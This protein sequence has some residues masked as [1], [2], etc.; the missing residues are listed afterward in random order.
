MNRKIV[1]LGAGISGL[2]LGWFL[3]QHLG[4]TAVISLL[5]Q[6]N[7][8]G[9]WIRTVEKG[10]FLFDCGPRSCRTYGSGE[11]T[12]ELVEALGLQNEVI[13]PSPDAHKR[14]IWEQGKLRKL[15]L[16]SPSFFKALFRDLWAPI[17]E[18]DDTSIFEFTSRRFGRSVAERFFDPLT[19]GI[20]AGNIHALSMRSCFPPLYEAEKRSGSVLWGLL[21]SGMHS[22]K[23]KSAFVKKIQKASLFSFRNGMQVLTDRLAEALA[24]AILY[25]R[26]VES[27]SFADDG[28]H[29][30][31]AGGEE[32]IADQVYS[33]LPAHVL[34]H[35]LPDPLIQELLQQIPSQSVSAVHFGYSGGVLNK[36]GFGYLVP[37][38]EKASILG[39]VWDSCVFPQQNRFP[40]ETRLTVMIRNGDRTEASLIKCAAKALKDHLG[41][42]IA[43]CASATTIAH[44]AIPQYLVG[45]SL[46][47]RQLEEHVHALYPQ[48]TLH[49]SSFYGVSVNDCVNSIRQ[50][51]KH[52][53][54]GIVC[55]N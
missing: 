29:I 12:L 15:S 46:R 28:V 53:K 48:L 39:V 44:Q 5:E 43:P 55:G 9:G 2:S 26:T 50:N 25:N 33:T 19:L 24:P 10:G 27:L 34:A 1:I 7:R 8:A 20:Y 22:K 35:L 37:S 52:R 41:I 18:G 45:H 32:V 31:L 42:E 36:K 49:G 47:L 30:R 17:T 54:E 21:R 23:K 16:C 14:Y 13:T 38:G 6:S 3:K 11:A 51:Q 40:E 4:S